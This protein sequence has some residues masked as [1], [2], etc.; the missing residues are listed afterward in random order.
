MPPRPALARAAALPPALAL[1]LPLALAVIAPSSV[2]ITLAAVA[3]PRAAEAD[4][5]VRWAFD[6]ATAEGWNPTHSLSSFTVSGGVLQTAITGTDPY[7]VGPAVSFDAARFAYVEIRARS[8]ASGGGEVFFS[9]SASPGIVAGNSVAFALQGDGAFHRWFV[10]MAGN[11]RWAGTIDRLRLDFPDAVGK[12]VELDAVAAVDAPFRPEWFFLTGG[13]AEGWTPNANLTV[14]SV[15]GGVLTVDVRS[16]GA[17]DPWLDA[18]A[19]EIDADGD[20]FLSARMAVEGGAPA[21]H[22]AVYFVTRASPSWG[23]DKVVRFPIQTD[24]AFHA[25]TVDL[26]AHPLWRSTVTAW[27]L[28]PVSSNAQPTRVRIDAVAFDHRWDFEGG[29]PGGWTADG[30][31]EPLVVSASGRLETRAVGRDPHLSAPLEVDAALL[32]DL[33]VEMSV[34]AAAPCSASVFFETDAAPISEA[35]RVDFTPTCDGAMRRYVAPLDSNALWRGTATRIRIDPVPLET[36]AGPVD[37]SFEAIRLRARSKAVEVV[38]FAPRRE[39]TF[40]GEEVQLLLRLRAAGTQDPGAVTAALA[41]PAGLT[42]LDGTSRSLPGLAP[43]E[44]KDLTFRLRGGTVG[45]HELTA[46]VTAAGATREARRTVRVSSPPPAPGAPPAGA[47]AVDVAG[48]G[49]WVLLRNPRLALAVARDGLGP[50][51][52]LG[53]LHALQDGAYREAAVLEPLG[54]VVERTGSAADVTWDLRPDQVQVL[55]SGPAQASVKLSGARAD[56]AGAWSYSITLSLDRDATEVLGRWEASSVVARSLLHFRGPWLRP[57]ERADPAIDHAVFPGLEWLA[58]GEASSSELD[59]HGPESVRRVPHPFK[60]AVPAPSVT[61][62]GLQTAL[63]WDPLREWLPGKRLPSAVFDVPNRI[64]DRESHLLG[65][66][67]PSVPDAVGEN[68]LLAFAPAALAAGATISLEC[69]LL[70]AASDDPAFAVKRWHALHDPQPSPRPRSDID[71][72]RLSLDGFGESLWDPA[73]KGWSHALQFNDP[74]PFPCMIACILHGLALDPANPKAAALAAQAQEALAAA[75]ADFGPGGLISNAG[76]H[77]LDWELPFLAG[78]LDEGIVQLSAGLA[79]LRSRQGADGAW[80]FNGDPSLGTPGSVELG[81]CAHNAWVLLKGAR[82]SGDAA[83]AAAGTKALE[84]MTAFEVPRAAQTWEIPVH[85][86]DILAAAHACLANV[87]GYRFAADA[88]WLDEAVRRAEEGLPFL[89]AWGAPGI[90][91]MPFASISVF[92]ATFYTG[93]WIGRPVQ[94][95]GLVHAHALLELAAELEAL[96]DPRA[97]S[98]RDV[99]LGVERSALHQQY[100]SGRSRGLLPDSW[101][102]TA[103]VPSPADINPSSILHNLWILRGERLEVDTVSIRT[104]A[105]GAAAI[106]ISSVPKAEGVLR[107]PDGPLRFELPLRAGAAAFLFVTGIAEPLGADLDG[108]PL[109][110]LADVDAAPASG[111]AWSWRAGTGAFVKVPA[112]AARKALVAIRETPRRFVRGDANSDGVVDLSDAVF[113][114]L[115]LFGGGRAPACEDALDAGDSGRVGIE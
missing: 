15:Q 74:R 11:P 83:A 86:P 22:A 31:L 12:T 70:A 26:A 108:S 93:S 42:P 90:E 27:R 104:S 73:A 95:C 60:V 37:I 38:R 32:A 48:D 94:W 100:P 10:P 64:E 78:H 55:A 111:G 77:L 49:S 75:L 28:D 113:T 72:L 91:V 50:G 52:G 87:E 53:L 99:A 85:T 57:G 5:A 45:V 68:T 17:S 21:D 76:C 6:G 3:A 29:D 40:R 88:R 96:G 1:P 98:F 89:Y 66:F 43:G 65:L 56:A 14:P 58:P 9:S 4:D 105:G 41:V 97:A 20:R 106:R 13:D 79:S 101:V 54:R 92:G 115:H 23:E 62:S 110:K 51:L 109:P 24:G 2:A 102:L 61:T 84:R 63:L 33:E 25:Y 103:D 112:G 81:T 47:A 39:T 18:P 34:G 8:A 44:S 46:R 69:R 30:S 59:L 16:G 107:E 80:P 7:M 71:S 35:T 114:L 67:A 36:F 82:I 19:E